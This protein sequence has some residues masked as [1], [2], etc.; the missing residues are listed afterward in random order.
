MQRKFIVELAAPLDEWH[1][2]KIALE[3][4]E[5][6]GVP[7]EKFVELLERGTGPLTKP[8]EEPLAK[9]TAK[10]LEAAGAKVALSEYRWEDA[11]LTEEAEFRYYNRDK[12]KSGAKTKRRVSGLR[13]LKLAMLVASVFVAVVALYLILPAGGNLLARTPFYKVQPAAPQAATQLPAQEPASSAA[14]DIIAQL[15]RRSEGNDTSAQLE[16][17]ER[18][19]AGD[20][21]EQDK[22][23]GLTYLER[24]AEG[25]HPQAQYQLGVWYAEEGESLEQAERWLRSAVA[26]G[27]VEATAYL[28]TLEAGVQAE[29]TSDSTTV[30]ATAADSVTP[31]NTPTNVT[32]T[33]EEAEATLT[34]ST[35]P[36]P[37]EAVS[38]NPVRPE[39]TVPELTS[40]QLPSAQPVEDTEVTLP[41]PVILNPVPKPEVA[42]LVRGTPGA[43]PE[44]VAPESAAPEGLAADS[45]SAEPTEPLAPVTPA[46]PSDFTEQ[47]TATL[48]AATTQPRAGAVR[49]TAASEALNTELFRLA[50]E[51]TPAAIARTLQAGADVNTRDAYGQTPLMYAAAANSTNAVVRLIGD[52]ARVNAKSSAGWTALMYAARDNP[53]ALES[54]LT[55][56][57]DPSLSNNDGQTALDIARS[58]N[59]EAVGILGAA[60]GR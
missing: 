43:A 41:D 24:A 53:G 11:L 44:N 9:R 1:R 5:A 40:P 54:L 14:S 31:T 22:L 48:T 23:E 34:E 17:A 32:L 50:R 13:P 55:R 60:T 36:T 42:V 38:L 35:E 20:G 58:S 52:G 4:T 3:V 8:L 56:G 26:A 28:D 33:N 10:L 46:L 2:T 39:M 19:L 57:A 27:V 47:A 12:V 30:D 45:L 6:L 29:E 49:R 7:A 18:Y 25:G 21:V 59:L 16:L 15:Q 37:T 51:G